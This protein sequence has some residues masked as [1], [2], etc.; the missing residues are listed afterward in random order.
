MAINLTYTS[1]N[2]VS[3]TNS[4]TSLA[5][6]GGS[7][8]LPT[9]TDSGVYQ[10]FLDGVAS[11]VKSD[12]YTVKF[13]EKAHSSG[14]KRVFYQSLIHGAQIE[15]WVSPQFILGLGWDVTLQRVSASSRNFYWSI[16]RVS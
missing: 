11:L 12:E 8:S 13:Y 4:E 5:V 14:T 15:V 3:I 7:T 2:N 10:L 1:G 9:L 16:R 6:D